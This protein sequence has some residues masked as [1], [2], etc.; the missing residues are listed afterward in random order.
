MPSARLVILLAGLAGFPALAGCFSDR[1]SS[2]A[3][4]MEPA[5]GAVA[6]K[7]SGFAF[8]PKD[9]VVSTGDTV[10]WTNE[11]GTIHTVTAGD[12]SFGSP[13]LQGGE[14]YSFTP[15]SPGSFPYFCNVHPFMRGTLSVR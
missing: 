7:I 1:P 2:A 5:G 8:V 10:T 14:T 13:I 11:D 4:P 12:G 15:S 9:I 3:N 6:A